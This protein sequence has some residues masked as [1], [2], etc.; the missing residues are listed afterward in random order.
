MDGFGSAL[1]DEGMR[2]A[3]VFRDLP[4]RPV[5][6]LRV[7]EEAVHGPALVLDAVAVSHAWPLAAILEPPGI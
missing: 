7:A 6:P 4:I 1:L 2:Y 3:A 5:G